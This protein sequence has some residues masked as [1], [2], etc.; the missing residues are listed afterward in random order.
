MS[1]ITFRRPSSQ[2]HVQRRCHPSCII[3]ENIACQDPANRTKR[4]FWIHLSFFSP[5]Q[6]IH[7]INTLPCMYVCMYIYKSVSSLSYSIT[8]KISFF[9]SFHSICEKLKKKEKRKKTN[10]KKRDEPGKPSI[11][12]VI[13]AGFQSA[14]FADQNET[15][16]ELVQQPIKN[17]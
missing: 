11:S 16:Q 6:K 4:V 1:G 5:S 15:R 8:K 3:I 12:W 13:A 9:S 17:K 7:P 10:K 2:Y 14:W